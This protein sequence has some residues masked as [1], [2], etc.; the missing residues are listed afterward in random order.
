[1]SKERPHEFDPHPGDPWHPDW[2]LEADQATAGVAEATDGAWWRKALRR[3]S[4]DTVPEAYAVLEEVAGLE[5]AVE[6]EPLVEPEIPVETEPAPDPEPSPAISAVARAFDGRFAAAETVAHPE[7]VASEALVATVVAEPATEV[8]PE[9]RIDL[10]QTASERVVEEAAVDVAV[11]DAVVVEPTVEP[12]TEAEPEFRIDVRQTAS[13][14]VVEEAAVDA[15]AV[16]AAVVELEPEVVAEQLVARAA[17]V[18]VRYKEHAAELTLVARLATAEAIAHEE[19]AMWSAVAAVRKQHEVELRPEHTE[20]ITRAPL[21]DSWAEEAIAIEESRQR[22][23]DARRRTEAEVRSALDQVVAAVPATPRINE[24]AV[25]ARFDAIA[26]QLRLEDAAESDRHARTEELR[27]RTSLLVLDAEAPW[28][29]SGWSRPGSSFGTAATILNAPTQVNLMPIGTTMAPTVA[30][31]PERRLWP[32]SRKRITASVTVLE[33]RPVSEK[34]ELG[35]EGQ[36]ELPLE[37][38][39]TDTPFDLESE[40]TEAWDDWAIGDSA[41]DV[42][43]ELVEPRD[44]PATSTPA[45]A[46]P[47]PEAVEA[48]VTDW[49]NFTAGEYVQTATHEY[50]DLAAAVAAAEESAAPEPAAIAADMPGMEGSLVGL[51]DVVEAEGLEAAEAAPRSDLALRVGT[52]LALVA[53]FFASLTYT[54]AIA[55]LVV[56]VMVMAAGELATVLLRQHYHPVALF[57][58]LGTLGLLLGTWQYGLVAIPFAVAAT[59]LVV[60]LYFGLVAG[61]EDP[62]TSMTLTLLAVL[63]VGV[64]ASF[65]MD[66]IN[67]TEYRWLVGSLVVIVAVMDVAQYFVGKRFGKRPLAPVVSPKKTVAGLVGGVIAAVGAGVGL[68]F[69]APF[70][71]VTG[72]PAGSCPGR[73]RSDRGPRRICAQAHTWR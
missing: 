52:G 43:A 48:D 23:E 13:E 45:A 24:A 73:N 64:L 22:L 57:A 18:A 41:D 39:S 49:E 6:L 47:T 3:R 38:I 70:D 27:L 33:E 2:A 60:L 46:E 5:P 54:W 55:A 4:E 61:R 59:V 15:A 65:A 20:V 71:Q 1:M 42:L 36:F 67:A 14:P 37:D 72:G 68:S 21:D 44:P 8:E 40:D 7:P 63:W 17:I 32:W 16:E 53:L 29:E 30:Q 11:E 50:A 28:R 19:S 12:A 56:V 66:M 9:I 34:G 31:S 69:I 58:Y 26:A 62:L 25:A 51:D 10:R 35:D